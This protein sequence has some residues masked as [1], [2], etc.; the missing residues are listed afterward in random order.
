M[1]SV[2][3]LHMNCWRGNPQRLPKQRV[4]PLILVV[5]QNQMISHYCWRQHTS[6]VRHR[7]T[8]LERTCEPPPR[9]L[10]F[11]EQGSFW[12]RIICTVTQMRVQSWL[13]C[14]GGSPQVVWLL[15]WQSNF[16]DKIW[17]LLYKRKYTPDA[18]NLD[19]HLYDVW[20]H[21]SKGEFL[22]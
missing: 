13:T 7:K 17:G 9:W 12:G 4:L 11:L 19:K 10:M 21:K 14:N 20:G 5:H 1:L 2:G 8:K 6:D 16:T 15:R 22:L 3:Y 18:V